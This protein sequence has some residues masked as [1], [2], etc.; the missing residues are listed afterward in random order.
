MELTKL[1]VI[2]S[3]TDT[4]SATAAKTETSK[5]T[6]AESSQSR[7]CKSSPDHERP[8]KVA[9]RDADE[10]ALSAVSFSIIRY[11]LECWEVL[12]IYIFCCRIQVDPRT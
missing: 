5:N 4:S 11:C 6:E 1:I 3:E 12:L 9:K 2:S 10:D 7:K 8:S